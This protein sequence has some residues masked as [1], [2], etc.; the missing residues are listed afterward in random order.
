VC[1]ADRHNR[2]LHVVVGDNN[3]VAGNL[4]LLVVVGVELVLDD[5]RVTVLEQ[6]EENINV[7]VA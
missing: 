2:E 3:R 6:T 7:I 1:G 5:E 4:P